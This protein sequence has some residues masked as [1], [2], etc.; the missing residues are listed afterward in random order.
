MHLSGSDQ[1]WK[2]RQAHLQGL[3][4]GAGATG[5]AGW[6]AEN[7]VSAIQVVVSYICKEMADFFV[8]ISYFLNL[9]EMQLNTFV[10]FLEMNSLQKFVIPSKNVL[11]VF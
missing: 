2:P 4:K 9:H 1:K 7:L 11:H 6:R 5:A 3:E 10:I 8:E